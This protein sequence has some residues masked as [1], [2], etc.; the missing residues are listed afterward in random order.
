[1]NDITKNAIKKYGGYNNIT[2][3][4]VKG[5]GLWINNYQYTCSIPKE[6]VNLMPYDLAKEVNAG[7]I[8]KMFNFAT[9]YQM[10]SLGKLDF[11][12]ISFTY[13]YVSSMLGFGSSISVD[14]FFRYLPHLQTLDISDKH[15]TRGNYA[16]KAR[17]EGDIFYHAGVASRLGDFC[18]NFLDGR[19]TAFKGYAKNTWHDKKQNLAKRLFK[20]GAAGVGL[21]MAA[22][23][24]ET[25]RFAG[26]VIDSIG[27]FTRGF[28]GLLD[29]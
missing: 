4:K 9:L 3:I 28:R 1:M 15:F 18:N 2:A 19:K 29:D 23:A 17:E 5:G 16:E 26:K 12:S 27:A 22:G 20:V 13:D 25:N 10:K 21:G 11:D 7:C 14:K 8:A 24:R 6:Y